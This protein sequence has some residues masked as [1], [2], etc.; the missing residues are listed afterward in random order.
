MY[1]KS[2]KIL[3][4]MGIPFII[5]TLVVAIEL[6]F[7]DKAARENAEPLPR[8]PNIRFCEE[9]NAWQFYYAFWTPMLLFE[10]LLTILTLVKGWQ[11]LREYRRSG[12][13]GG[14]GQHMI[15]ILVYDSV[16]YYICIFVVYLANDIVSVIDH[17][18]LRQVTGVFAVMVSGCI[19][20]R[21]LFHLR[22]EYHSST[23][24]GSE[25]LQ[26]TWLVKKGLRTKDDLASTSTIY[27]FA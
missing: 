1:G 2:K 8:L 25:D 17:T 15:K 24:M 21:L 9:E 18:N 3:A 22:S 27:S 20:Q 16:G 5:S 11:S 4:L 10:S 19:S 7:F 26:L 23:G 13:S 14:F 6:V 12:D